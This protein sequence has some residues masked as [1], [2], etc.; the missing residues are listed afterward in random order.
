MEEF[1]FNGDRIFKITILSDRFEIH[2]PGNQ[3]SGYSFNDVDLVRLGKRV[4][5]F[6]SG[7]SFIVSFVIGGSGDVY[8]EKDQLN[9]N[10]ML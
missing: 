5:W 2:G 1:V 4:N 9:F 3:I 6:V 7:L 10:Y 8:K